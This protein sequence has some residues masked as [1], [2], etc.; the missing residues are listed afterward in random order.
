MLTATLY[1]ALA[2]LVAALAALG[3]VRFMVSRYRRCPANKLLV[4]SGR[5]GS[6]NAAKTISGGG[7]FVWPVIQEH[8]YMDLTPMQINIP[9]RDALSYE[10]IRVAVPSVFTVAIGTDADVQQNA[11]IRLL[12]LTHDEIVKTAQDI[13]FGQLRQVIA[14]M[15]IEEIN[16]DRDA[17]LQKVTHS[18]EPEL[19]KIGLVLINVN[20]TD[21]K[22]DSGYIEAIGRKA[23]SQAVNQAKG[24]V[25]EQDKLGQVRVAEAEREQAVAVANASKVREI[26][27]REASGEQAVRLAEL[28]KEQA[29]GEQTAGFQRDAMV[30]AAEQQKRI[31]VAEANAVAIAGEA[32]AQARV[33]Q[34]QAELAVKQ[35]E[36][37]QISETKRREAEAAVQEAQHR[38]Q[39]RAAAAEAE[40][41]EAEK[42]AALEGPARADKAR[43]IV[44]A[45]AEAEQVR[46]R[47]EAE[48]NRIKVAA[49]AEAQAIYARL[50]AQARGEFEIM[51]KRAEAISRMVQAAGGD[52]DAAF[53]LMMVEQIPGM[54]DSAARAISNIKFD[55]V[56]VWDGGSGDGG[57]AGFVQ[58]MARALPPMMSV[59]E[60]VGGVKLPGFLGQRLHEAAA[61]N[62]HT[63]TPAADPLTVGDRPTPAS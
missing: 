47:A 4:I 41:I 58:N 10:N 42:R 11:A 51:S 59:I 14:S 57:T 37:F 2:T 3:L 9:L 29:V 52:P 34:T 7:A 32:S 61:G 25:A 49:G 43:R 63:P 28:T 1:G 40:R 8:A 17:F 36:T 50:D 24:D 31:A 39:A 45:E 60:E 46:I 54:V 23:A 44:E 48:A 26:G 16:R 12:G 6:T 55:K 5:T 38:A 22:D 33:A 19:K 15:R 35:A 62:G 56:I 53:R 18:L 21:L 27:P 30:A 20:I 13:I